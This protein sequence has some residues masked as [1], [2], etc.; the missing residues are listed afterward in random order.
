MDV[1]YFKSFLQLLDSHEK[2]KDWNVKFWQTF[3][4]DCGFQIVAG[5]FLHDLCLNIWLGKSGMWS[6]ANLCPSLQPE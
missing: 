2:K 1:S 6:D 5:Y 3:Q 4:H